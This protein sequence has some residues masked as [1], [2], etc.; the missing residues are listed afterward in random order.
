METNYEIGKIK[1]SMTEVL[2]QIKHLKDFLPNKTL[3]KNETGAHHN[4]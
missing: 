4:K 3:H 1:V 2:K